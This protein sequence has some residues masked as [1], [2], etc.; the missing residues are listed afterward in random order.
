M[1]FGEKLQKARKEK[2]FTQAEIAK[3]AGLGLKTITN[4]EKG[5]TYP[6]NRN[7]YRILAEILGVDTAYLHN[8]NDDFIA[9][10]QAAH[11]S[12][13]RRQAQELMAEVTGLFAG[14]DM[15]EEDMDD[16]VKA[17]QEAYWDA[18]KAAR[19]KFTRKDYLNKADKS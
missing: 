12:R 19:E 3:K 8:E 14:G 5:T 1:T 17:V 2:G 7:V 9:D 15:A 13:G 11:G 4:Y 6:Q 16:F 18:K 10:A